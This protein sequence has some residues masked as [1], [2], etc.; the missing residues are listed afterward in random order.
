MEARARPERDRVSE[1]ETWRAL[2]LLQA[3]WPHPC[4]QSMCTVA[5]PSSAHRA[6]EM[7]MPGH[8]REKVCRR[9][10][11][12]RRVGV[13][14]EISCPM[15]RGMGCRWSD[16]HRRT[17]R[18][19]RCRNCAGD[20]KRGCRMGISRVES[21]ESFPGSPART[22]G[23]FISP[24]QLVM[25]TVRIQATSPRRRGCGRGM[26]ARHECMCN[27]QEGRG[28]G[29]SRPVSRPVHTPNTL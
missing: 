23:S 21:S 2:A 1:V 4:R 10:Q 12:T 13:R 16:A 17:G 29:Q 6:S 25:A 5:G 15:Q 9:A 24:L 11:G 19:K 27:E 26:V 28:L 22:G 7:E 3:G 14:S 18:Q 20:G 8:L